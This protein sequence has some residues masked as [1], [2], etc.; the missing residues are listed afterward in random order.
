VDDATT[1]AFVL[2]WYADEPDWAA[3]PADTAARANAVAALAAGTATPDALEAAGI[4]ATGDGSYELHPPMPA[5]E[6]ARALGADDAFAR[7]VDVHMSS[8]RLATRAG[9]LPVEATLDGPPRGE[10]VLPLPA[11]R[12]AALGDGDLVRYLRLTR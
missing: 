7:T 3:P 11:A 6:L 1:D 10:P 9:D 12:T 2:E 5:L 4:V 8:W